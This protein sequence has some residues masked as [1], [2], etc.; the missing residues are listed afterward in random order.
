VAA[1]FTPPGVWRDRGHGKGRA[2][3]WQRWAPSSIVVARG[4]RGNS[5]TPS[6]PSGGA[7]GAGQPP[8]DSTVAVLHDDIISSLADL[9]NLKGWNLP[10]CL[11]YFERLLLEAALHKTQGNQSQT[12]RLLGITPRSIYN[13]VHKH[14]LHP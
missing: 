9:L 13:K 6:E 11:E 8:Q 5:Q 14:H 12:A 1:S 7:A 3:P 2:G 4:F 10:R